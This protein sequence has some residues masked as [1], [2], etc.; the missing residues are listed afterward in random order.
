[1]I[2]LCAAAYFI[3]GL[4]GRFTV[5]FFALVAIAL[6]LIPSK[7]KVRCHSE[8]HEKNSEKELLQESPLNSL[9]QKQVFD[10]TSVLRA[11]AISS[12]YRKDKWQ[13]SEK[14]VDLLLEDCIKLIRA[15]LNAHTIAIFFPSIDGGL[16]LR[17]YSSPSQFINQ[18]AII[19]PGMGVIGGFLKEGLKKLN[20][21][22][23]I[24]D[25]STLFYYS[26]DAGVR[27]LLAS[28]II[29]G[30][31]ERGSIIV[32]STN[33]NN[34]SDEDHAFLSVVASV[35][36]N[37]VFNAYLY[38]EHKLEHIR[39]AAMSSIEKE[40]FQNL[41]IDAI[42]DKMLEVIPFTVA[43]NRLTISVKSHKENYAEIKRTWGINTEG[44]E[45]LQFSLKEKNLASLIYSK[46]ISIFRNFSKEHYEIRYAETEPHIE[47]F[48]SF[49]AVPIGVDDSKGL[50]LLES[51][52]RNAFGESDKDLLV[53]LAL[54]AGLAIEKILILDQARNLATHDGLTGLNNHREFQQILSDE[55]TRAIR[56][57]DS[58]S[59][60]ICDIDFF[61]KIND[62]YGHQFGDTVL[63]GVA[64]CLESCIR[65]GVDTAARYGGEEFALI[66]VKSD[67]GNAVETAERIR[68]QISSKLFK[69]PT[70]E[71]VHITMSF[72]IAV[73]RQH[74]RQIDELIK[75]ADKALYRA[76]DNGRN[77]VEVF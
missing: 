54:S 53:R 50:I 36:G 11:N 24:S 62:T 72:G 19:Y 52:T 29:A 40:F 47:E 4:H 58:L 51:V 74:A 66:L 9:A 16:K 75:R 14:T 34:F 26:Q 55:I 15:H 5:P 59:L 23:I 68:Q 22:E 69:A 27:S 57:Q 73:Y 60:I 76:K 41:S 17:K 43:C 45:N 44:L 2:L 8:N 3:E 25:S 30:D 33:K 37:A 42:L 7:K 31:A 21:Q 35:L 32:D 18:N 28:P 46:N 12:A 10:E 20:L 67:V 63:K 48:S 64:S 65:Q 38:T 13:K 77:R 70:G 39:L 1:M 61:K 49:L 6:Y 71:D 56:Y